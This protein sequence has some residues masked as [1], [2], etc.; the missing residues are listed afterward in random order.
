MAAAVQHT[1]KPKMCTTVAKGDQK[2][3]QCDGFTVQSYM[4]NS[5]VGFFFRDLEI[6]EAW[7]NLDESLK[8]W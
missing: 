1:Q 2:P 3:I 5:R 4:N 8:K 6:L 7:E